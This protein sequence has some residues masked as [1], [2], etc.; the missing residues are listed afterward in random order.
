MPTMGSLLTSSD[1]DEG[2]GDD[3]VTPLHMAGGA[4]WLRVLG[5]CQVSK[6]AVRD[7][8]ATFDAAAAAVGAAGAAAGLHQPLNWPLH[9]VGRC[10]AAA[11]DSRVVRVF[12]QFLC[13]GSP[14]VSC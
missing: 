1:L 14:Q 2:Q 6:N 12:P 9:T 13:L 8:A 4:L 3:E 7:A 5:R 10:S 11:V